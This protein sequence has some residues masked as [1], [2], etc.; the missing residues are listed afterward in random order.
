MVLATATPS[1]RAQQSIAAASVWAGG[2]G[3]WSDARAW[4]NY[5]THWPYPIGFWI[6]GNN[7]Q[8]SSVLLDIN[9]SIVSLTVGR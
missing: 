2:G 1:V 5:L 6:D 3:Y 9:A 8:H 7:P 4:R